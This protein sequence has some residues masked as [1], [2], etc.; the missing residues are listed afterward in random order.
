[1][2]L[3]MVKACRR[4]EQRRQHFSWIFHGYFHVLHLFFAGFVRH[5]N[6]GNG[7]FHTGKMKCWAPE[8]VGFPKIFKQGAL[9]MQV[10][11]VVFPWEPGG[12]DVV[13]GGLQPN[14]WGWSGISQAMC[15]G[16]RL[17]VFCHFL[18]VFC[19]FILC[20]WT[21]WPIVRSVLR[22]FILFRIVFP[23]FEGSSLETSIYGWGFL[24]AAT[25]EPSW[26]EAWNR[27]ATVR[28]AV[29][30]TAGLIWR[31]DATCN[32]CE[33]ITAGWVFLGM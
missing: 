17:T 24:H 21:Y 2:C 28:A 26:A 27:L 10:A 11:D 15:L 31:N 13:V 3:D 6:I 16:R 7:Y 23:N 1:M 4:I 32:R 8:S 25:L 20:G 5:W 9:V 12:H 33:V 29:N 19:V 22:Y 18:S 30:K 14:G